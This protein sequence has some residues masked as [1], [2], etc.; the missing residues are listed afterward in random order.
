MQNKPQ[1]SAWM[2]GTEPPSQS[3]SKKE[4]QWKKKTDLDD[5]DK[6]MI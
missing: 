6:C 1:Q 4:Q 3:P 5:N 2:Y